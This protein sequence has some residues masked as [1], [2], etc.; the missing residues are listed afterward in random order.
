[1]GDGILQQH[2]RGL[3]AAFQVIETRGLPAEGTAAFGWVPGISWRGHLAFPRHGYRALMV[4]D[5]D[6]CRYPYYY[7]EQDTAEKI[8]YERLSPVTADLYSAIQ[9][10]AR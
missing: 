6:F 9:C 1:M 3:T 7:T 8:D 10:V 4:T 2:C 5:T